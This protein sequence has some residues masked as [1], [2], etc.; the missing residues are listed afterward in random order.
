MYVLVVLLAVQKKFGLGS[1]IRFVFESD[2]TLLEDLDLPV[3]LAIA[4]QKYV[5]M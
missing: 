1:D 5:I 4:E 2:G 3:L